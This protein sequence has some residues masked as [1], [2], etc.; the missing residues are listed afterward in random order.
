[1]GKGLLSAV[2]HRRLRALSPCLRAKGGR[3]GQK[4]YLQMDL[5]LGLEGEPVV[6]FFAQIGLK[7][8]SGTLVQNTCP[9]PAEMA[10]W[11]G[12]KTPFFK[13]AEAKDYTSE[14]IR[15]KG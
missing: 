7:S 15:T 6:F 2:S 12:G 4:K 5:F 8:K 11:P 1:M 10:L 9:P 14:L 3:V 13:S